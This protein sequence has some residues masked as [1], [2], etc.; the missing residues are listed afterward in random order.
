LYIEV[1]GKMVLRR[2]FCVFVLFLQSFV[3]HYVTYTW[4]PTDYCVCM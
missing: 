1:F 2:I 4:S 3:M